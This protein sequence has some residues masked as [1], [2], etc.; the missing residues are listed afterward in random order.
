MYNDVFTVY[1]EISLKPRP[2]QQHCRMLQVERFFR[3]SRTLL[4]HC[5]WCGH[6]L[7]WRQG[8]CLQVIWTSTVFTV[9]TSHDKR[10]SQ[11]HYNAS[12][13]VGVHGGNS[14]L[15]NIGV[16]VILRGRMVRRCT[17]HGHNPSQQSPPPATNCHSV[18]LVHRQNTL[19]RQT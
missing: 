2:H 8:A 16:V 4:W 13:A 14:S 3:Q 5:C 10:V 7:N 11:P 19:A 17:Q 12:S 6:G 18:T 1:S 15:W 9:W